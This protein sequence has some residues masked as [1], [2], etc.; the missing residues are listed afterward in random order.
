MRDLTE[1]EL[2]SHPNP[3]AYRAEQYLNLLKAQ[4][5]V[6]VIQRS[7]SLLEKHPGRAFQLGIYLAT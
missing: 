3:S 5:L 4:W 7:R 1:L 6:D 2:Q